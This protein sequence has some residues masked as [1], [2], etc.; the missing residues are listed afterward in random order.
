MR[1]AAIIICIVS[2]SIFCGCKGKLFGK[3]SVAYEYGATP[4]RTVSTE[5]ARA[6]QAQQPLQSVLSGR[7][8]SVNEKAG[9]V[10]LNF[11]IGKMPAIGQRLWIYRDNNRVGAVKVTGP[12]MDF[13]IAADIIEGEAKVDDE[14]RPE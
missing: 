11:P 3:K 10:I 7:V 9:F 14:A 13:N 4:A 5:K 8:K 12:Q 1:F 6:P 2:I